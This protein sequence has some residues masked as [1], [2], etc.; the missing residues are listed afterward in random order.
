VITPAPSL[1]EMVCALGAGEHLIGV[2]RYCVYPAELS[3]IP[4]IGGAIDPNLEQIDALAPDL[5]LMQSKH[6]GLEALAERRP[7][8]IEPFSIETVSDVRLALTRL[9]KLLER[10]EAARAEVARLDGVLEGYRKKEH[11][12]RPKVLLVFSRRAGP[13]AQVPCV[14]EKT[15]ISEL[16]TLAGGDNCL[17]QTGYPL[18]SAEV[19]LSRAPDLVIE[20]NPEPVDEAARAR[21]RAD[22]KALPE[23][24]AVAGG[25]IAIVSGDELLLPGPRLDQ[26]L[27]KLARALAGERDVR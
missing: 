21:L 23:V 14:G 13:L 20:L 24:P 1:A 10:V 8:R 25:G 5:V 16:L 26:T 6:A 7:W 17:G 2:S 3:A 15:F 19:I 27:G 12:R 9:G 11:A 18:V 22:W 4:R